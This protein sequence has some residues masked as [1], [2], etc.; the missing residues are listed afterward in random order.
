MQFRVIG[1]D[2]S[3]EV[4]SRPRLSEE[5]WSVHAL[6]RL[7]GPSSCQPA[8][9]VDVESTWSRR[10]A[11]VSPSLHYRRTAAV[12]LDYGPAFQ[13]V[14][15]IFVSQSE[16]RLTLAVPQDVEPTL[17]QYHLH[18]SLLD[19][20]LQTLV[21]SL[22]GDASPQ[23][24]G[25][26]F[27]PF[28]VGKLVFHGRGEV[29]RYCRLSVTRVGRRSIL[30]DFALYDSSGTVV[31]EMHDFRFRRLRLGRHAR[32]GPA[33][34]GYS[35][36]L[37][38]RAGDQQHGELP[39]PA[40]LAEPLV[41]E[42]AEQW[43]AM[44]RADHYGQVL[45]LF[46]ALVAGYA[47]GALCQLLD[48][49]GEFHVKELM[50][51][52]CIAAE[53][54]PWFNWLLAVLEEDRLVE[55]TGPTCQLKEADEQI[56]PDE[57]WRLLLADFPG[58]L[59]EIAVGGRV[60]TH[61]VDLLKG[62]Y[63]PKEILGDGSQPS[64][65]DQLLECS[66]ALRITER[67]ARNV[68]E[69]IAS[70]WPSNRRFRVLELS[71]GSGA[72]SADVAEVLPAERSSYVLAC[73]G[74]HAA[75][76]AAALADCPQVEVRELDFGEDLREQG[77][78]AH[79]FDLVLVTHVLHSVENPRA[80]LTALRRVMVS[81]GVLIALE[82]PP[83]RLS[84]LVFGVDPSWWSRSRSAR[85]PR[86]KLRNSDAWRSLLSETGFTESVELAEPAPDVP[87]SSYLVLA[88]NPR[89]VDEAPN[90]ATH[91][92][93]LVV[94][95][96]GG[97]S[98][99]VALGLKAALEASGDAVLH[100]R[101][102]ER[103]SA[104]DG[105]LE[106][107]PL[108]VNH[109][110]RLFGHLADAHASCEEVV[111]LVGLELDADA[112]RHRDPMS[113]Q[114]RRCMPV[115]HMV[116]AV[117]TLGTTPPPRL[118]LV[119]AGSVAIDDVRA[120]AAIPSQA[121]LR[122]LGRVLEN[123]QPDMRWKLLDLAAD[124]SSKEAV[125]LLA[126]E[127]RSPDDEDE[128]VRTTDARYAIRAGRESLDSPIERRPPLAGEGIRLDF[129]TPGPLSNLA[130]RLDTPREPRAGEIQIQVRA[131]GLNFR[132]VM[133]AMGMLSDEAVEN[134]FA[135]A[136][137]GMECAGDVVAVGADVTGFEVGDPV[138][139]FARACFASHV[140]TATTAVAQKPRDW[141]YTE[142]AT[143]PSVFFTV[144]YALHHLA[145]LEAGEKILIHGAAGGVGLAA[146]QYARHC[147][148]EIFATAGSDEKRD[149]LRLLGVEHVLN[150]RS[151][152][153]A[154][155]IMEI[156]QGAGVDVVLNSL[157]G[158]AV[159][160]NLALLKPFGRFLELG[161][162][163][164]YENAKIGL[165]P[166]RNN[167]TYYGIDADQ[168][169]VERSALAGRLFREMMELF[170][171]GAFRSLVHRVFPCT[172]AAD[173]FR[174]MQQ[175]RHIGKIIVTYEDLPR[176]EVP[177]V[178]ISADMTLAAEACYL[179]SGG[180]G[181]FGM[182][183]AGWLAN[184]GARH[185]ALAGRRGAVGEETLAAIAAIE[186]GG[187]TVHALAVDV[188]DVE[189]LGTALEPFGHSLP[190]IKGVIHAAM[191]LDDGLAQGLNVESLERVLAPKVL[192]AWNLHHCTHNLDFFVLYSSATTD[193]GN[194]GQAN[195]V[196]ANLYLEALAV[197]R[198]QRGLPAI[199]IGW[200]P[201][202]DVGYLA[203][204]EEVRDSLAARM[205]GNPL[206]VEDALEWLE[207]LVAADRTGL[208][209]A[210]LDWRV[211]RK[212]LPAAKLAK[213]ERLFAR[214]EDL[215]DGGSGEDMRT[216]VQGLSDQEATEVVTEL[217]VDQI[218]RVMRTSPGKLDVSQS[219]YDL[220]MD[221]LMAVELHVGIEDRFGINI[222]IMAVTEDASIGRLGA[223]IA[224][225]LGGRGHG[226]E[227]SETER[228]V[229]ARLAAQHGEEFGDP[230]M[231]GLVKNMLKVEGGNGRVIH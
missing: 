179:I 198:R 10:A 118:W 119:N 182:A 219:V 11:R 82:R 181:G 19:G 108:N 154:D 1:P 9:P 188:T 100:A 134:G 130:W 102:G 227:S 37:A 18:P 183:T 136:T 92:R 109:W 165:R 56:E 35:L 60:G 81:H 139:C 34:Y 129:S 153:F 122:G 170:E 216:L 210:D 193:F 47:Y 231:Q 8:L 194:P 217:L 38:P 172:R 79:G 111:H 145:G 3:F 51:S 222:P 211:L 141:S 157:S 13:A 132:D 101:T 86:S 127:L 147:G 99:T 57:I 87:A 80:L 114:T 197:Y 166:F 84:D 110:E 105:A 125:R 44:R 72:L 195:Y 187:T 223:R 27:L 67:A 184:K 162:R 69:A 63:S 75:R 186:E 76:A 209:L 14:A 39:S 192:G 156:T 204:N 167:I 45:P 33:C 206:K 185:I 150:S 98:H 175:S 116:N 161:K 128:V 50:R 20:C 21:D 207:R 158:E 22:A 103:F 144:Y 5:S 66:P 163:D 220:G 6:G 190:P 126:S 40:E 85:V 61:L 137:L 36:A 201:I 140:T 230:E 71:L 228:S 149:F 131:T 113:D 115:I 215:A 91:R 104:T 203:R 171:E 218:A 83:E 74:E 174:H 133:Y 15:D 226:T 78:P 55:R 214:G 52:A 107:D 96:P 120:G 106:L 41:E 58:Y 46:D 93:V 53:N 90:A 142:A 117:R 89:L 23:A 68:V 229:A 42:L 199:S 189:A 48:G 32:H 62:D 160:K 12:G 88:R 24:E 159:T 97:D 29:P 70:D 123:E 176:V 59:P 26:G 224:G 30:A 151:L 146:I 2:R 73:E 143:I 28:Q 148:A 178:P 7:G 17:D 94:S 25:L 212:S 208:S 65:V 31:A 205:G 95:D 43:Y 169:L 202:A 168:L 16:T 64:A 180:F 121:P 54:E 152:S 191:V 49:R 213:F 164:F 225:Q 112:E 200:G 138:V 124:G 155:E 4:R 177:S 135:G 196:A 221:S 77:L 173:A